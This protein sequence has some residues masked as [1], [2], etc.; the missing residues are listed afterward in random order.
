MEWPESGNPQDQIP[1]WQGVSM[2]AGYMQCVHH[3][4]DAYVDVNHS[5]EL[6]VLYPFRRKETHRRSCPLLALPQWKEEKQI[7]VLLFCQ[8][9]SAAV[10]HSISSK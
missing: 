1:T 3:N 9:V 2:Y 7:I 4:V 10:W 6:C 5:P 8:R